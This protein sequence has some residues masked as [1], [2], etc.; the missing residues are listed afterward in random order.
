[1]LESPQGVGLSENSYILLK[2]KGAGD[3]EFWIFLA[4]G[5]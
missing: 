3:I 2:L 5:N 4:L 1:M